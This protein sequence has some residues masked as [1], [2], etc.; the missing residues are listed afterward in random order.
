MSSWGIFVGMCA[1]VVGGATRR[2]K[3]RVTK[4]PMARRVMAVSSSKSGSCSRV[5]VLGREYREMTSACQ[6]I[7]SAMLRYA[8]LWVRCGVDNY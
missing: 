8:M 2:A 7:V 3:A 1:S 4:S 5:G 6:R